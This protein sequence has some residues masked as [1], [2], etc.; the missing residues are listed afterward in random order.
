MEPTAPAT[1]ERPDKARNSK[2]TTKRR[3]ATTTRT[4]HGADAQEASED[5]QDRGSG[6]HD[7]HEGHQAAGA[8]T[9]RR[10]EAQEP[11]GQAAD[12]NDDPDGPQGN[13]QN[14]PN[15]T[16]RNACRQRYGRPRPK[17]RTHTA[18]KPKVTSVV[19]DRAKKT[20]DKKLAPLTP[21]KPVVLRPVPRPKYTSTVDFSANGPTQG[22]LQ[23]VKAYGKTVKRREA[24]TASAEDG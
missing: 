17:P 2:P 16:E 11:A 14:Q 4:P 24:R 12:Q 13:A 18:D 21:L 1:D 10:A 19:D 5:T 3:T 20:T 7:D 15:Q 23:A 6:R 22:M 8:G 9:D